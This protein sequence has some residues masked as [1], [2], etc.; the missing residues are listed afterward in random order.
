MA[1]LK[2]A[3]SAEWPA[4]P[5]SAA[6]PDTPVV[7]VVQVERRGVD[8]L[9]TLL[10]N[11]GYAPTLAPQPSQDDSDNGVAGPQDVGTAPQIRPAPPVPRRE[12][13]W[14]DLTEPLTARELDVLAMLAWR[15]SDR[16]IADTLCISWQ[17]VST[18]T[19]HIYRK[20]RVPGRRDAV[21]RAKAL[22]VL[23]VG[24]GSAGAER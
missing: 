12:A 14:P 18:H 8:S 23:P 2:P 19:R 7:V 24:R 17:T 21:V 10:A 4:E 20:L 11:A 22:G 9:M 6:R 5:V 1:V 3:R 16:E 13:M 15:F